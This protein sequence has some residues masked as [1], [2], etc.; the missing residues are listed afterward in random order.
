MPVPGLTIS[1]DPVTIE[2][3]L[4]KIVETKKEDLRGRER[5]GFIL[6]LPA[7]GHAE[8]HMRLLIVVHVRTPA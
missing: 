8:F 4:T 2:S 3:F 7:F 5:C 6:F 1:W